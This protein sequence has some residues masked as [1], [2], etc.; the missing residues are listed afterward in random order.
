MLGL[1]LLLVIQMTIRGETGPGV[2]RLVETQNRRCDFTLNGEVYVGLGR[3]ENVEE[4]DKYLT[5]FW[6]FNGKSW[7]SVASFPTVGRA[8][9]VAFVVGEEGHQVAYVGTGYREYLGKETYYDNFILSM[10]LVGVRLLPLNSPKP[11]DRVDG[12]RRD[13]IAFSLNGKGYVGTGLVSGAMVVNDMYCFDPSKSGDDAWSNVEF[14][15]DPRCG[16]VAFCDQ[17]Q[18]C[19]MSWCFFFRLQFPPGCIYL[20]RYDL[21]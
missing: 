10:E 16:A 6:K 15:G 12:G 19:G 13:G 20:R 14:P 9:A 2:I 4:K 3:N 8:G 17:R 5:D 1:F 18:S 21:G 11:K 7:V